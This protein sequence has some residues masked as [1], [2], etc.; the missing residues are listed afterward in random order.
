MKRWKAKVEEGFTYACYDLYAY[1]WADSKLGIGDPGEAE[2]SIEDHK[3]MR[4]RFP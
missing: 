2:K 3:L 4:S 1:D